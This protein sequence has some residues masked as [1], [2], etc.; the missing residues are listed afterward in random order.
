M[1]RLET[2]AV[3]GFL[4]LDAVLRGKCKKMCDYRGLLMVDIWRAICYPNNWIERANV[5]RSSDSGNWVQAD[6]SKFPLGFMVEGR[7]C[8][9]GI[10]VNQLM[11]HACLPSFSLVVFLTA[12]RMRNS[13]STSRRPVKL[14]PSTSLW[15]A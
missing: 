6:N 2:N 14:C 12:L 15:T 1:S 4:W 9:N 7:S 5:A 10:R 13:N 8:A 11:F 3:F